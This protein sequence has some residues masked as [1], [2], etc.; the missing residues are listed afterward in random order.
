M[1]ISLTRDSLSCHREHARCR[2][3][4]GERRTD[5]SLDNS[6]AEPGWSASRYGGGGGASNFTWDEKRNHASSH[7]GLKPPAGSCL[8][9]P[10]IPDP[11]A[12]ALDPHP[13]GAHMPSSN[14]SRGQ[15]QDPKAEKKALSRCRSGG[16][17][18]SSAFCIATPKFLTGSNAGLQPLHAIGRP[19]QG[20]PPVPAVRGPA[21]RLESRDWRGE[22]WC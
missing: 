12:R 22:G 14:P 1:R 16:S 20:P 2:E 9:D 7:K 19:V 11:P 18:R 5:S 13:P 21:H 3:N 17:G 8:L 10:S 4:L 15:R 6:K